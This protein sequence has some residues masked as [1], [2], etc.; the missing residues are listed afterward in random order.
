MSQ[1][2]Y[3]SIHVQIYI[4]NFFG[5]NYNFVPINFMYQLLS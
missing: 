2:A 4:P 5:I 3:F 1:K